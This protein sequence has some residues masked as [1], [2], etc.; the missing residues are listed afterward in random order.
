[1]KI[2]NKILYELIK[3]EEVSIQVYYETVR[4]NYVYET[5]LQSTQDIPLTITITTPSGS[6]MHRL[7]DNNLTTIEL[8]N[9]EE[10]NWYTLKLY[11][12]RGPE[13]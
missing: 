3:D 4:E 9:D 5:S 6:V 2:D 13:D 8:I 1:M 11:Y 10:G 7:L 12:T